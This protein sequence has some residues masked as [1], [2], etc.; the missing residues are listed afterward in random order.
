[1]WTAPRAY[2]NTL[3]HSLR[4]LPISLPLPHIFGARLCVCGA[5][6]A[7]DSLIPLQKLVSWSG[8][9]EK[10]KKE[11]EEKKKWDEI[12]KGFFSGMGFTALS[13]SSSVI[14]ARLMMFNNRV[15]HGA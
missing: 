2:F 1:M 7:T 13:S 3:T 11:E 6:L 4:S 15:R 5:T 14:F 8:Q 9:E 10:K 12:L